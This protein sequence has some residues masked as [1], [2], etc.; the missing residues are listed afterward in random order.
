MRVQ[1]RQREGV[2]IDR[3]LV[4]GQ[5]LLYSFEILVRR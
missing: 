4:K 3:G 1:N 2:L 5:G